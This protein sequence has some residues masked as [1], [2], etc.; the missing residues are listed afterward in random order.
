MTLPVGTI[1]LSQVNTE[2]QLA[3]TTTIS[4]NQASVRDLAGVPSGAISMSNLQGKTY[5]FYFTPTISGNTT[6]YNIKSAAI[7]AG[8]DQVRPLNATITIFPATVYVYSTSTGAY[9]FQTGSTFPS[10]SL[11]RLDNYGTILGAGGA[12]GVGAKPEVPY[13]SGGAGTSGGPAFLAQYPI[14][15]YNYGS[16]AGGG[17]GG[18]GGNAFYA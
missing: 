3:S 2:L 7:A 10:G 1:S 9:A 11:L 4:L 17:G 14:T 13:A 6:N 5:Y 18:G 16:I 12:G 15:V 8:W